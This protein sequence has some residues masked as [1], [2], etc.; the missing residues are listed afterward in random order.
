V[1]TPRPA[2]PFDPRRPEPERGRV[3]PRRRAHWFSARPGPSAKE[4]AW[5]AR[6]LVPARA[7]TAVANR[8]LRP[9]VRLSGASRSRYAPRAA[10]SRQLQA[11]RLPPNALPHWTISASADRSRAHACFALPEQASAETRPAHLVLV[12]PR[13]RSTPTA[14]ASFHTEGGHEPSGRQA[15]L[16]E[17][18]VWRRRRP[19]LSAR[20]GQLPPISAAIG[21]RDGGSARSALERRASDVN[22]MS[23]T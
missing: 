6:V 22:A 3:D 1:R 5:Q 4:V 21:A 15:A 10:G 18:P 8:S 9:S 16:V 19:T 7:R 11:S 12:Q 14:D 2:V 13:R 20:S 17:S 23:A